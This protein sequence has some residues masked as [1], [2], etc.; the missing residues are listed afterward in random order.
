MFGGHGSKAML[1]IARQL[2]ETQ[3]ILVCGHNR[4][5]ADRLRAMNS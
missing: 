5:L 3:L 2:D 4:A 1:Q